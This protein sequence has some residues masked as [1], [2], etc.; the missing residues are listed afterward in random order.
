MGRIYFS[1]KMLQIVGQ[2]SRHEVVGNSRENLT[3]CFIRHPDA[4][5]VFASCLEGVNWR[6][7]YVKG[8]QIPFS[9]F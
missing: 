6:Y 2:M 9:G 4:D 7:G 8:Y 3:K 5:E 1:L